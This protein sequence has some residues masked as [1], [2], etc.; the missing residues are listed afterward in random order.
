MTEEVALQDFFNIMPR[1]Y[2]ISK[3][4]CFFNLPGWKCSENHFLLSS[5]RVS[6]QNTLW[7]SQSLNSKQNFQVVTGFW[8][9]MCV[10]MVL[11]LLS[12][13]VSFLTATFCLQGVQLCPS[14]LGHICLPFYNVLD[15]LG[16]RFHC[17]I[18]AS[19]TKMM[20]ASHFADIS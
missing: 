20:L 2:L 9:N 5:T 14:T 18:T 13:S 17:L 4:L 16:K 19:Q 8:I 15:Q 1:Q 10:L 3:P 6:K 12:L 11:H 7:F